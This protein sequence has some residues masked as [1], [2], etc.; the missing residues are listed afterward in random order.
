MELLK[1]PLGD[2]L[3]MEVLEDALSNGPNVDLYL[4]W[5]LCLQ[6]DFSG[7]LPI[8]H[9]HRLIHRHC[10]FSTE[11]A[12][13]V[14]ALAGKFFWTH[15]AALSI[16]LL[17]ILAGVSIGAVDFLALLLGDITSAQ[18]TL[19]NAKCPKVWVPGLAMRIGLSI[20]NTHLSMLVLVIDDDLNDGARCLL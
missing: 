15:L 11:V 19:H 8:L 13:A 5:S 10:F 17:R 14:K 7:G 1:H 20:G 12:F 16:Y 18:H 3:N 9:E 4:R 6:G 2:L